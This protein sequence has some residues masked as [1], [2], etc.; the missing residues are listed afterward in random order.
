MPN[1]PARYGIKIFVLADSRT[2][3]TAEMEIYAGKQNAGPFDVSNKPLDLVKRMVESIKDSHRNVVM[4]NWF[5]SFPL[6]TELYENY[7]LTVLGTLRKNKPEIPPV[8]TST[9]GREPKSTYF[10]FQPNCTLLSYAP[11]K[12]KVV[13]LV[14]TMHHDA[15]ID[16]DTGDKFKPN[17]ITDYNMYKCGVDV[18]DEMCGTYSISRVSKRWPLTIFFGLMNV[19]AINAYVIYN[20][21]MKRLQKETVE[22]RHF[23]KDLALGLVMPQ[24]Q[25]RSS[26]TTLPRFIRKPVASQSQ[27]IHSDRRCHSEG[28]NVEVVKDLVHC[29]VHVKRASRKLVKRLAVTKI[30][31]ALHQKM[32]QIGVK[33]SK[34]RNKVKKQAIK[35]KALQNITTNPQFLETLD[36]MS[37]TSKILTLLQFREHKKEVKGRRFTLEEKI[38]ALTILKQSPKGYRFL[39]KIFILPSRQILIKLIHMPDI[40]AGINKNLMAQVQKATHKMKPEHKLCVVLF[41]EMSL[42]PNVAYNERKDRV[43]G[44]VTNG[45]ETLPEYADHA[46]VFMIRGLLKNFKQPVAY[47]FSQSSTKGPELAKQL[48]AVITELQIAGLNVVATVCD[49]GTNNVNCIKYLLQETRVAD[50]SACHFGGRG[51]DSRISQAWMSVFLCTLCHVIIEKGIISEDAQSTADVLLFFDTLFD[52]VNGSYGKRKKHSKPLLGPATPN[53]DP[54][55]NF[56]GSIRSQGCRNVN[57]TPDGFE[58]AF[59]SLLINS[60][61][62]VHAAGANCEVDD[63]HTLHKVLITSG[64]CKE[65]INCDL[66]EIPDIEFTPLED[67]SDPRIVGGLQYVSGYYIKITKKKVFKGCNECKKDLMSN[68]KPEYLKYREYANKKW[69]CSPS[70]SLLNCVSNLQDTNYATI[71]TCLEKNH[72]KEFI[73]TVIFMHIQFDWINVNYTKKK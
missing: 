2:Y 49:Q 26:I 37:S 23:L 24:I 25:K 68:Q 45:Q 67:K 39:R 7:G 62:S 44:F 65:Q 34:C 18:V 60:L 9:K 8:F 13:L 27:S 69:L 56:F 31:R 4:D 61:T 52:S 5:T 55:E 72:L 33:L 11:K 36:K 38:L 19:G 16:P 43:S 30:E 63:C 6:I 32:V 58:A 28:E 15:T 59:S 20:A 66:S 70:N 22:R 50:V 48:K 71:K 35:I 57:P 73:K 54:I 51:L 41:D 42:K 53:S 46:Q 21:N 3:Y 14:S 12:G 1:K 29:N 40:N 10:G 17:M 47:T 64:G